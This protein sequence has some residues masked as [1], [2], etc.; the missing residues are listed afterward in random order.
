MRK[1]ITL[2]RT[3]VNEYTSFVLFKHR[4]I[5]LRTSGRNYEE[6]FKIDEHY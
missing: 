6:K 2:G 3:K 4:K 5:N 1:Y